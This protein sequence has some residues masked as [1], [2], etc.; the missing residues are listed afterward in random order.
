[1]SQLHLLVAIWEIC[2][3]LAKI[4]PSTLL[5]ESLTHR[6]QHFSMVDSQIIEALIKKCVH[7]VYSLKPS[8]MDM[9]PVNR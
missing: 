6:S 8:Y 5:T 9:L 1:M 7:T 3:H 2:L 4:H